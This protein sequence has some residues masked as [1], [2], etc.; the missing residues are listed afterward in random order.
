MGVAM[1][2]WLHPSYGPVRR[3][4]PFCLPTIPQALD[5]EAFFPYLANAMHT[6]V[7][8]QLTHCTAQRAA[9]VRKERFSRKERTLFA[10]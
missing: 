2:V 6:L 9:S 7:Q 10:A 4:G 1:G 3:I 5:I 8:E